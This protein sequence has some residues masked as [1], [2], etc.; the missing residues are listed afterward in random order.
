MK[1]ITPYQL[2]QF[3][4]Y[5]KK[6]VIVLTKSLPKHLDSSKNY[7]SCFKVNPFQTT[8]IF[9]EISKGYA[10]K[11]KFINQDNYVPLSF[12]CRHVERLF[13]GVL[14][15]YSPFRKILSSYFKILTISNSLLLSLLCRMTPTLSHTPTHNKKTHTSMQQYP[16]QNNTS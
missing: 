5:I 8:A 2:Q 7:N 4:S 11:K 15:Q 9:G 6:L 12:N 13:W 14:L 16:A 10:V 3:V 1:F